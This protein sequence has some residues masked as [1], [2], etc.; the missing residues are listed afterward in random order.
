MY[1]YIPIIRIP[2][3]PAHHAFTTRWG[4]ISSGSEARF[5]LST[6]SSNSTP[7]E[8][9]TNFNHLKDRLDLQ[10]KT[11]IFPK[12]IHSNT[13]HCINQNH[14][15]DQILEGDGLIS[16]VNSYVL[17]VKVADCAA[18]YFYDPVTQIVGIAHAGWKGTQLNI[19]TKLVEAF[20][21]NY[22]CRPSNIL[23]AI[24]PHIQSSAFEVGIEFKSFFSLKYFQ[25]QDGKLYFNMSLCLKDQLIASGINPEHIYT[26]KLCTYTNPDLFY[27]YRHNKTTA[28]MVALIWKS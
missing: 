24:S 16:A 6:I 20:K 26:S 18:I 28:R 11:I 15:S 9:Q 10:L 21:Q 14:D 4:G 23:T 13:I 5:N 17:G 3:F 8:Y 12:Q 19:V 7:D 27:S 25:T 22:N 2:N 1:N